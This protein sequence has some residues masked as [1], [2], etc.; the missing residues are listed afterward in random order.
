MG[1]AVG[2]G[3]RFDQIENEIRAVVDEGLFRRFEI[4]RRGKSARLVAQSGESVLNGGDL[5]QYVSIG[6]KIGIGDGVM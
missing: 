6:G 5:R 3:E 4:E 1:Q 2:T